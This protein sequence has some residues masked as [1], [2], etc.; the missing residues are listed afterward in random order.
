MQSINVE[1]RQNLFKLRCAWKNVFSQGKLYAID[2]NINAIDNA[3][4]I[5]VSAPPPLLS[6]PLAQ[7]KI[8]SNEIMQNK[9]LAEPKAKFL[10][11][12]GFQHFQNNMKHHYLGKHKNRNIL[13]FW[14]K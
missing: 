11:E 10:S 4:P 7:K 8:N 5:M 3:W 2:V 1:I 12:N 9:C 13:C 6:L 14:L